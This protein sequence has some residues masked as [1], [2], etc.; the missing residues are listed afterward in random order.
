VIRN[1]DESN[2]YKNKTKIRI[3]PLK[4]GRTTFGSD[5]ANDV[6]L[7][8]RGIEPIHC[9]IDNQIATIQTFNGKKSRG[10]Q[11]KVNKVTLHP[12]GVLCSVEGAL[13]DEP[14]LLACG[15]LIFKSIYFCFRGYYLM[16][17][18][19]YLYTT[20][21]NWYILYKQ[22]LDSNEFIKNDKKFR[23]LQMMIIKLN[24]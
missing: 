14:Y 24:V 2:S 16:V 21:F 1:N 12:I 13:I 17:G 10:K 4:L 5:P 3:Y 15:K 6:I 22:I 20:S 11:Y 8:G 9:F 23:N 7:Q 18:L 19:L